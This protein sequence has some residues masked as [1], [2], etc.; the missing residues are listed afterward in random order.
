MGSASD[1][2]AVTPALEV[3]NTLGIPFE[4]HVLSAHRTP[5]ELE[6]YAVSLEGRGVKVVVAAAGL[7]AA[8]PGA[9]AAYTCL[10]VIGLPLNRA[11]NGI[12]SLL[13]IVQMPPRVP[14]AC[15]GIDSA[16]NAA[17]LAAEIVA[18]IDPLVSAKLYEYRT[19]SAEQI[20]EN[21][22]KIANI[23]YEF[24]TS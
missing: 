7:S 21:R 1:L 2:S 16:V 15:V 24:K 17:L 6:K 8:L 18:L 20:E 22:K 3:L 13:S 12:D 5:K 11:V 19:Y 10:P 23:S 14:V 4:M 9:I